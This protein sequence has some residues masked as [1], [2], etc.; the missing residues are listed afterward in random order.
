MS[1]AGMLRNIAR[2]V[3]HAP[4]LRRLDPLWNLLRRPYRAAL[5]ATGRNGVPVTIAGATLRLAPEFAGAGWEH[6]EEDCYA[7]FLAALRPGMTVFDVGAHIGTYSMLAAR[8]CAPGGQVV[9]FEP[10]AYTRERLLRH[11]E[12]NG[13]AAVVTVLPMGAGREIGEAV[14]YAEPDLADAENSLLPR[15]GLKATRVPLTTI[16]AVAAERGLRPALIKMDIEG[17]EWDALQGAANTLAT[18]KPALLISLHPPRLAELGVDEARVLAWF[19][20]RGYRT[21]IIGR[22]HE[23]HVWAEPQ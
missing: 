2:T 17:G 8:R 18:A 20:E 16:D 7:A 14:F 23:V 15:P 13:V 10:N 9:A 12:W 5:A 4:G 6:A 11:L 19:A 3:R 21:K 1:A 22:D